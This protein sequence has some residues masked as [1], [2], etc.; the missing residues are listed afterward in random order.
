MP[1]KKKAEVTQFG[2]HN[3]LPILARKIIK[4]NTGDGLSKAVDIVPMDFDPGGHYISSSKL[5][6][7]K[8]IFENVFSKDDP[9]SLI[10]Y[11]QIDSFREL[12]S[13]FDDRPDAA[14]QIDAMED[15]IAEKAAAK[16]AAEERAKREAK[17][18]FTFELA[19]EET[20]VVMS[21][22]RADEEDGDGDEP[23]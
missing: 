21:G 16:A 23:F 13:V 11:V 15:R 2:T 17:G 4:T 10:G 7:R 14:E 1:T 8:T 9:D 12:G 18:E 5:Q 22:G 20:V 6:H 19:E 3:K